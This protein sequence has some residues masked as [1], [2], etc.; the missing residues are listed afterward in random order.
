MFY[1]HEI[2]GSKSPLGMI[3]AL[4]HGGKKMSKNK[5]LGADLKELCSSILHPNV[6]FALRL[7]GILV[8]GI[9]CVYEKK[10]IYLLRDLLD[11]RKRVENTTLPATDSPDGAAARGSGA[12]AGGGPR[13]AAMMKDGKDTARVEAITLMDWE[14]ALGGTQACPASVLLLGDG[15]IAHDLASELFTVSTLDATT[16][17]GP[18]STMT[19]GTRSD[20]AGSRGGAASLAV[21]LAGA[22]QAGAGVEIFEAEGYD[23]GLDAEEQLLAMEHANEVFDAAPDLDLFGADLQE[24]LAAPGGE[25]DAAL[26][27]DEPPPFDK[28]QGAAH[29]QASDP[30]A[31]AGAVEADAAAPAEREGGDTK[32]VASKKRVVKR[33]AHAPVVDAPTDMQISNSA[34]R[35][36]VKDASGIITAR[37]RR[38]PGAGA[39]GEEGSPVVKNK[40]AGGGRGAWACLLP[41]SAFTDGVMGLAA[42]GALA[43]GEA[44]LAA[45]RL[46]AGGA[47]AAAD[48]GDGGGGAPAFEEM[49]R[50][51]ADGEG[52]AARGARGR[53]GAAS[54]GREGAARAVKRARFGELPLG[55]LEEGAY[56]EQEE[57]FFDPMLEEGE[58]NDT[59]GDLAFGGDIETERLRDAGP[60]PGASGGAGDPLFRANGTPGSSLG[61]GPGAGKG[62]RRGA[63]QKRSGSETNSLL[64]PEELLKSGAAAWRRGGLEGLLGQ[65]GES[66]L[67]RMGGRRSGS[68]AGGSLRDLLPDVEELPF[69]EEEGH[70]EPCSAALPSSQWQ[71]LVESGTQHPSQP[72]GPED[73]MTPATH[74]AIRRARAA[75][76]RRAGCLCSRLAYPTRWLPFCKGGPPQRATCWPPANC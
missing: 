56:Y 68:A 15:S 57:P 62:A 51:R 72:A 19:R 27:M 45:Y 53:G 61:G 38:A 74:T 65:E 63:G 35:E 60:T 46:C 10:Q 28:P 69:E 2:L 12:K 64:A 31:S 32:A 16:S 39:D 50:F 54:E 20:A 4:A 71:L 18:A 58:R 29:P 59:L 22:R 43:W 73:S 11:M 3:W 49:L 1:S 48:G 70:E 30:A 6:P 23:F 25:D 40:A 5:I 13:G 55:E 52:G 41:A 66:P 36:W 14:M 33:R 42:G 8:N 24:M 37:P 47:A 75:A 76:A 21:V 26:M 17:L 34:Y 44:T 7:Q 9:V 67:S